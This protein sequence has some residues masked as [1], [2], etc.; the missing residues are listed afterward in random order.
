MFKSSVKKSWK[1]FRYFFMISWSFFLHSTVHHF[2]KSEAKYR[3]DINWALKSS[4]SHDTKTDIGPE[5][6]TK[7][8]WY[9]FLQQG[10]QFNLLC[11]KERV[12]GWMLCT[13]HMLNAEEVK[14]IE[15]KWMN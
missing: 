3:V 5:N 2:F 9:L 14:K 4:L 15:W 6:F 7:I 12:E 11:M 8:T 13:V 10:S 1:T